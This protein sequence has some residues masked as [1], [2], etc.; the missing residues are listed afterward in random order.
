V[1]FDL[2]RE[3]QELR[4]A[5]LDFV[6]RECPTELIRHHAAAG[7][8]EPGLWRKFAETGWLGI[9]IPEEYGGS[10]GDVL[11]MAIVL[12]A[13]A[14]AI[15]A[16]GPTFASMCF[17]GQALLR[18]GTEEQKATFLPRL[19][20]GEARFALS[21]TEPGGGTDVL[22]AMK[23]NA[24]KVDGGWQINGAKHYTSAS[25]DADHLVVVART[26]PPGKKQAHGVSVFLVDRTAPGITLTPIPVM[27]N[28]DTNAV[29]YEDVFVPD[30]RVLGDV[31]AGF[32]GLLGML[33]NERL[34]IGAM[35]VGW[36]QAGL[37]E[38]K[39][40]ALSREAFG[41]V[42]GRFQSVQHHIARMHLLVE[43][44]RLMVYKAAWLQAQDR[45]CGLEAT[46][47]KA[48]AAEN[49][50]QALDMGMQVLGGLGYTLDAD[51]NRYWRRVR[52][53]RLAPV[54]NEM[55]LNHI[56]EWQ[57]MPRSF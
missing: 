21:I 42:I 37:E 45:P 41:G 35:C 50:F 3:Q 18:M 29:Y 25:T 30:D 4:D 20:D 17:G 54:S 5:A 31:D 56:A 19:V 53:F 12:E 8:Y 36:G 47:A 1:D 6:R 51:L 2:T 33:N 39:A 23:T 13:T 43:Q 49:I 9:G 44:S 46:S 14:T 57:G 15:E 24:T 27:N 16:I 11:D 10:G 55:A 26:S 22:G 52:L 40:H 34:G 28:E 32:Y 7:T 48:V 38:V